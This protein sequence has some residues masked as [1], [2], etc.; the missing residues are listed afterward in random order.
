MTTQPLLSL[1]R[2]ITSKRSIA[3]KNLQALGSGL[4]FTAVI[5]AQYNPPPDPPPRRQTSFTAGASQVAGRAVPASFLF[6]H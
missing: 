3:T 1:I 5:L 2:I 6:E 4:A